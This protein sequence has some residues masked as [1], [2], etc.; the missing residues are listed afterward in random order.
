[1]ATPEPAPLPASLRRDVFVA[2]LLCE[3]PLL[4]HVPRTLALVLGAVALL[5]ALLSLARQWP[6]WPSAAA[7]WSPQG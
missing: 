1:M 6:A 3:L 7:G 5:V 2:A 4:L